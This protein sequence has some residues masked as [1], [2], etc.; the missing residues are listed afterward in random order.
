[1][2][3]QHVALFFFLLGGSEIWNQ[4]V[5][6]KCQGVKLESAQAKTAPREPSMCQ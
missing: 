4:T 6:V 3:L 1:M 5:S 2:G